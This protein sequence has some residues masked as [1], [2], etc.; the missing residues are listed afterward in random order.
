MKPEDHRGLARSNFNQPAIQVT[1]RSFSSSRRPS[2]IPDGRP[3]T[4]SIFPRFKNNH[5]SISLSEAFDRPDCRPGSMAS[6]VARRQTDDPV[7][8]ISIFD[9][10]HGSPLAVDID[11]SRDCYPRRTINYRYWFARTRIGTT[12]LDSISWAFSSSI[13]VPRPD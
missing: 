6:D 13:S 7:A 4:R 9:P 3:P 8:D 1:D 2:P 5:H 10:S 11:G 12:P